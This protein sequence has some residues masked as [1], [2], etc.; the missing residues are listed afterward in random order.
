MGFQSTNEA[1]GRMPTPPVAAQVRLNVP[2]CAKWFYMHH[3]NRWMFVDGEWLPQLAKF[4]IE[5]GLNAVDKRGD[6][7][8]A[9]AQAEKKGWTLLPWDCIP[10]LGAYIREFDGRNGYVYLSAWEQ[11]KQVGTQTYIKS[12]EAGYRD[13]L[14]ELLKRGIVPAPDPDVLD[15]IKERTRWELKEDAR[16]ASYDPVVKERMEQTKARLDGMSKP[17]GKAKGAQPNA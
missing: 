6:H 11:V 3:P 12:D 7:T 17:L 14:R 15:Q 5:P 8:I 16:A 13:F 2:A 1:Q 10:E 9:K 4:Q